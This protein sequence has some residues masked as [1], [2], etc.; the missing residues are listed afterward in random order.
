VGPGLGETLEVAPPFRVTPRQ[1]E[2]TLAQSR[3]YRIA[4]VCGAGLAT[5]TWIATRL[6]DSL[7]ERGLD[8]DITEMK[9]MD[10]ALSASNYDLIVSASN[11]GQVYD[12]P[13]VVSTS[14]LTGIGFEETVDK[15]VQILT[16]KEA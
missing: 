5:S 10:L 2:D 13:V 7:A 11:L 1:G 15:I 16:G 9:I 3:K 14:V 4:S 6:R 8:V 12:V